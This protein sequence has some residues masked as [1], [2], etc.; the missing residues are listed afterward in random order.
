MS[1]ASRSRG[2]RWLLHFKAKVSQLVNHGPLCRLDG[3]SIEAFRFKQLV[4]A[5]GP[6]G[7]FPLKYLPGIRADPIHQHQL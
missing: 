7:V 6:S 3:F 2:F 5:L 1:G 4:S